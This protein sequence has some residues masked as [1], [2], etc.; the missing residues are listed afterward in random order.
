MTQRGDSPTTP[1]G[2]LGSSMGK[3]KMHPGH[4]AILLPGPGFTPKPRRLRYSPNNSS[5]DTYKFPRIRSRLLLQ[6]PLKLRPLA[7]IGYGIACSCPQ[8]SPRNRKSRRRSRPRSNDV[9]IG[10]CLTRGRSHF[11]PPLSPEDDP[12]FESNTVRRSQLRGSDGFSPSS[13]RY[14]SRP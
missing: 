3:G 4:Q 11:E 2:R 7:S 8:V 14:D 1:P 12:K 9:F 10:R 13:L 6:C 5:R